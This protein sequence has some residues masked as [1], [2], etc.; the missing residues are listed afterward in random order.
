MKVE[1]PYA[2][3]ADL[4]SRPQSSFTSRSASSIY[5]LRTDIMIARP[6]VPPIPASYQ[7]GDNRRRSAS[8]SITSF[9]LPYEHGVGGREELSPFDDRHRLPAAGL[10]SG[11][12]VGQVGHERE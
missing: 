2:E 5:S 1:E 8:A 7:C 3:F 9:G 6:P 11:Y 10:G 4:H 12:G